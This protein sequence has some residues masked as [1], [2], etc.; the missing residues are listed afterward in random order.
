MIEH[1]WQNELLDLMLPETEK[2]DVDDSNR[3]G[4]Q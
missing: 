4:G 1:K 3:N 2:I